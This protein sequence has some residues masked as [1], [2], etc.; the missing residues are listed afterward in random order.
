MNL[1]HKSIYHGTE[2]DKLFDYC[3]MEGGLDPQ[4]KTKDGYNLWHSLV[5]GSVQYC[6]KEKFLLRARKLHKLGI[7]PYE[8]AEGGDYTKSAIEDIEDII[9]RE[10]AHA[11]LL[12]KGKRRA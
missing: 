3:L 9:R 7:S 8:K 2:D 12:F 10:T 1:L 6:P 4:E 5:V 11:E